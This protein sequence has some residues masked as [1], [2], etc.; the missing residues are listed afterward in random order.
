MKVQTKILLLLLLIV[1][2]LSVVIAVRSLR[3]RKYQDIAITRD[4]RNRMFD[5]FLTVRGDS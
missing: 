3:D 4:E 2:T 1:L 5:E